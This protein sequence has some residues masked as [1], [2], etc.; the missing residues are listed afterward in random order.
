M[1]D[2]IGAIVIKD[3]KMMIVREKDIDIFFIPGGVR[4]SN[5]TDEQVLEREMMEEA[6]V[7]ITNIRFY[8]KFTAKASKGSGMVTVKSYFC[9]TV[10]EPRPAGEIGEIKWVGRNDYKNVNLGNILKIMIPALIKDGYL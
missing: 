4:E 3:N 10:E 2:K 1:I 8:S 6:G 5:E 9:D 7:N